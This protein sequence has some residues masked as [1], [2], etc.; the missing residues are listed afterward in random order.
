[1]GCTQAEITRLVIMIDK[2]VFSQ[3]KSLSEARERWE[4]LKATLLEKTLEELEAQ[5]GLI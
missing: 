2:R 3:A 5:L 1:M 4:K